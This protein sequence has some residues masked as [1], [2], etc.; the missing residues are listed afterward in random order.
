MSKIEERVEELVLPIASERGL[1]LYDVEMKKEGA[2]WYLR[3]Y[4][5]KEGGI[6]L[7]D[8]EPVHRLI[9]KR[10]DDE[11][12]TQHDFLEVSSPGL[13]RS[14]KKEK[15]FLSAIGELLEVKLF[16]PAL[17]EKVFRGKL[18][19]FQKNEITL[20]TMQGEM[21]FILSDL[22]YAKTAIEF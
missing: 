17:G 5:E 2:A 13:E 8:L 1:S 20:E 3:I 16:K 12:I 4:L 7:D 10:L 19:A 14:L 21:K 11:G 18:T 15:H 6:G 22:A 9:D